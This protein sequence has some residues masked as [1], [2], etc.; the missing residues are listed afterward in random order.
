MRTLRIQALCYNITSIVLD[1]A[2]IGIEEH[3]TLRGMV[4]E[5]PAHFNVCVG[6][7]QD[8]L[9]SIFLRRFITNRQIRGSV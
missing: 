7:A 6:R 4:V 9:L 3:Y 5:E 8:A 1:R 2:E